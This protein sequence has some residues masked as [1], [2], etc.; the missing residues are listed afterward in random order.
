MVYFLGAWCAVTCF[1]SPIWLTMI[2]LYLSGLIY[3]YD[4]SIDEGIAGIGGVL[5]LSVWILL[6]LVPDIVFVKKMYAEDRK[7]LWIAFGF[8]VMIVCACLA[9]CHWDMVAFL[10]TPGGYQG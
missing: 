7:H 6:A 2:Y 4:F 8:A 3:Q 9:M 5:L 10:T 1:V